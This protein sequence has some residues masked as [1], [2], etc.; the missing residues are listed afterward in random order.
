MSLIFVVDDDPN[1]SQLISEYLKK[2]GHEVREFLNGDSLIEQVREESPQCLILDIMIPGLNGL[3]L[4]T[5]IRAF[6]EMPI[7]MIS[8][9]G[10]EMDRIMG[11]ELGSNDFLGK[12]FNPREL[13]GRVRSILR[14][15]EYHKSPLAVTD[16]NQPIRLG[17]MI[18]SEEYRTVQIFNG[19]ELALTLREFELLLHFAKNPNRPYSREQLIQQVWDYDFMGDV[20]IV[21]ELIK[22]LRKK[23]IE[24]VSG[25]RVDTVWGYGYKATVT[26]L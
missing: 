6:S 23:L 8:A 21:D 4:L 22:R 11:L 24:F 14:L 16:A 13:V 5:M 3:Q 7:I 1:I 9:R 12:P 18:I 26:E 20:R 2:D 19:H 10:D 15:V 17:N 25:F